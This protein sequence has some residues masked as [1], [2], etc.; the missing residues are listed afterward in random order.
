MTKGTKIFFMA[1]FWA[2]SQLSSE[3]NM[4]GK[5]SKKQKAQAQG[6]LSLNSASLSNTAD[7]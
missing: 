1:G 6:Q 4:L 7:P 2:L 3:E 5:P